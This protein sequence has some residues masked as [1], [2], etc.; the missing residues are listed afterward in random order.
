LEKVLQQQQEHEARTAK[1][2][3]QV[4]STQLNRS[5]MFLSVN[6]YDTLN[7]MK[8]EIENEISFVP[9]AFK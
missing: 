4:L 6:K 5:E 3:Q 8:M 1:R 7:E 2:Q 9:S